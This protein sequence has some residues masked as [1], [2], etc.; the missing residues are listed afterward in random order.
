MRSAKTSC[1][2]VLESIYCMLKSALLSYIQMRKYLE[3]DDFKFNPYDPCVANN[4]IE[5]EPLTLLL[6]ID[7]AKSIHKDKDVVDRFEK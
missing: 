3:T 2:W 6:Y 5:G 7:D 1:L 4:I